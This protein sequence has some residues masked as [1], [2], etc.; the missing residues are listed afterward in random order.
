MPNNPTDFPHV[1]EALLARSGGIAHVGVIGAGGSDRV[2]VASYRCYV[3]GTDAMMMAIPLE[4]KQ[5]DRSISTG[6]NVF[7][8]G[9]QGHFSGNVKLEARS[10]EY[11]FKMGPQ[12]AEEA[13]KKSEDPVQA[14]AI[15]EA[16]G[17]WIR[18]LKELPSND[19]SSAE[20]TLNEYDKV[21]NHVV[22]V[23]LLLASGE[24]KSIN[25]PLS[26]YAAASWLANYL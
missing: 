13:A 8:F 5:D 11:I 10:F 21:L 19:L 9:I 12:R 3:R 26:S 20:T 4:L 16:V 14:T 17:G 6:A 25:I 22:R 1:L 18:A 7:D 2:V 24:A 15:I 23:R